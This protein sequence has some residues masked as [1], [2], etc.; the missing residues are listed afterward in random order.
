MQQRALVFSLSSSQLWQSPRFQN[1]AARR[2]L[3]VTAVRLYV[4]ATRA[5][6]CS[7]HTP[8]SFY[9]SRQLCS[10]ADQELQFSEKPRRDPRPAVCRMYTHV[11]S[12]RTYMCSTLVR[13]ATAGERNL[14][15]RP[16]A[17]FSN[18][19][20]N[21][22]SVAQPFVGHCCRGWSIGGNVAH[23]AVA[24]RTTCACVCMTKRTD[25]FRVKGQATTCSLQR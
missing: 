24:R 19:N 23:E 2:L 21:S 4:C 16:A 11:N 10:G 25:C 7:C 20:R 14:C 15:G 6:D 18:R 3:E 9:V 12:L 13:Y 1:R 8:G 17:L 22:S 5:R